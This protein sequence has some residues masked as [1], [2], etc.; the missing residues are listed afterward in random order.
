[1]PQNNYVN[2]R[3]SITSFVLPQLFDLNI[4]CFVLGNS[5]RLNFIFR[6]F[7]TLCLFHLHRQI[8]LWRWNRQSVP[9]RWHIKFRRRGITQNKAFNIQNTAKVWKQE[10]CKLV[11]V[12]SYSVITIWRR[13]ELIRRKRQERYLL[14]RHR[15][16]YGNKPWKLYRQC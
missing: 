13:S 9:K 16:A 14:L 4:V 1:M 12:N 11:R 6:R 2:L 8:R 15:L 10:Y 3:W 7:G 5:R